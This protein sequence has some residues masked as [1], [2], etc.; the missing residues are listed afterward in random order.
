MIKRVKVTEWRKSNMSLW[1]IPL[2]I[3]GI[4]IGTIIII[5][6]KSKDGE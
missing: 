1:N 6:I 3:V 2:L 4:I 5:W